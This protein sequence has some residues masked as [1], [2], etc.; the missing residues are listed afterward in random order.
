[1]DTLESHEELKY[2]VIATVGKLSSHPDKRNVNFFQL[3]QCT[4]DKKFSLA[5]I[6]LKT[7]HKHPWP[8]I[9]YA[10]SHVS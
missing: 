8:N 10:I 3:L 5:I 9:R 4:Y 7:L 1:M 2:F 6:Q